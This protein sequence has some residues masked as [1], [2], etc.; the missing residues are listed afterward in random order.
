M[1]ASVLRK[2]LAVAANSGLAPCGG[3]AAQ[4]NNR[5]A[6]TADTA[7]LPV[8]AAHQMKGPVREGLAQ[9]GVSQAGAYTVWFMLLPVGAQI[10]RLCQE[11]E[12]TWPA[13]WHIFA[14][15]AQT[16]KLNVHDSRGTF[17]NGL[18]VHG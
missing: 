8:D 17:G 14:R 12:R 18:L 11:F 5:K 4:P 15:Q 9:E 3:L 16:L 13:R 7:C 2:L 6:A 1:L 10:A